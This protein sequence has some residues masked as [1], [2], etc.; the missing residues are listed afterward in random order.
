M[1][2]K[3]EGLLV[4]ILE[5]DASTSIELDAIATHLGWRKITAF[6]Y[7][8]IAEHWLDHFTP[9]LA[10]VDPFFEQGACAKVIAMLDDADVPLLVYSEAPAS[11]T[12]P[13]RRT[14]SVARIPNPSPP[15]VILDA[16]EAILAGHGASSSDTRNANA[17]EIPLG[18]N[19]LQHC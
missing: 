7:G 11:E 13:S 8:E 16:M 6:H 1:S 17:A 12:L 4:F 5:A 9:D 19:G 10:I 2:S 18:S 3:M 15:H 14:N